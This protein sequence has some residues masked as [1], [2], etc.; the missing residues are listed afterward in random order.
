MT[1]W[2][3]ARVAATPATRDRTIDLVRALG[4]SV[5]VVWHWALSIT[6]RTDEGVFVMSNPI[7]AVPLA[8]LATWLLQVMPVFFLIG[9]F[10]N[11]GSWESAA[12]RGLFLRRRLSRLLRPAAVW[13]AV[14]AVA[15][16]VL[17][18]AVPGYRGM[19]DHGPILVTPLWFLGAYL[20]VILLVPLTAAAHRHAALPTVA[21]LGTGVVAVDLARFGAGAEA[22]GMVNTAL[23]WVFVHQL[24]YFWRDG[25]LER[26]GRSWMLAAVGLVSLIGVTALGPYPRSMVATASG[27]LS[28][29][30]PTTAAIAALAVFQLGALLLLRRPLASWLRRRRVWTVVVALNSVAMTVY[31]WHMTALILALA[32]FEATGLILYATPAAPWWVQRPLWLLVPGILLAVIVAVLARV[33]TS[34]APEERRAWSPAWVRCS[35]E[36]APCRGSGCPAGRRRP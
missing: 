26:A 32:L 35:T 16:T 8:W 2:V 31:L 6:H 27:D 33:E 3:D 7:D 13:L 21:L 10:V 5:V 18:F 20:W 9:G 1:R 36:P 14:W 19:L 34:R 25:S 23:V 12:D 4:C 30:F 22:V 29:M 17:P 24:G 15:E 11:L 28:N